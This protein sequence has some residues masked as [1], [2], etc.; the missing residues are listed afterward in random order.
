MGLGVIRHKIWHDLWENK[1]RTLRVVTIIAIG[2]F[3]IGT[4]LGGKEFII[5]DLA[6]TWQASQPATI[7]LAV[8]PGVD[9]A[10]LESLENLRGIETV[11]GWF[12][13]TIKWRRSPDEPWVPAILIALDDYGEQPIRQVKL[14]NGDWPSRK[15][16]G[17]QRGRE[18][19]INDHVYL[20][21]NDEERL[22]QFNGI[23]Y[24][25]AHP[26]PF[27]APEPMFFTAPE[28]FEQLTG[29]ARSSL[30]L[31]TIPNYS[32]DRVQ[33]AADLIQHELEKQGVEVS[34]AIPA[35]GG[36]KTRTSQPDRF[37]VQ[38][39]LDGVFLMLT[40]MAVAT[41]ILGLF[42]VYNTINAIIAQ[43]VNQ[44]GIMKAIGAKFGKILF[45][46]FTTVIVYAV[47][48]LLIAVPLGAF[49]AHGLRL[50]MIG[51]IRMIPG[52]LEISTTAVSVQAVIAL[53]S[54]LVIAIIPIL[55]GARITV[56]EAISIYGLGGASGLLDRLLLKLQFVPRIISLTVSNTFRNKNRVVLTQITLVGA[57]VIFMMVMSTRTSLLYTFNDSIFTIFEVNVLLDL[58]DGERISEVE[59]VT[60]SHPEVKAVEVWGTAKGKARLKGQPESNDDNEVKLRGLP[61]PSTTYIPQIRAGRWLQPG[62]TYAV[63]LNQTLAA[64]MDVSVGNWITIDIPGKREADWQVVGLVFEPMD[65]E[66]ALMPRDTLL[67]ESRQVGRGKAIRVQTIRD[68]AHSEFNTAEALRTLYQAKGYEVVAST[69]NT[70]HQVTAQRTEQMSILIALLSAMAVMIAVVGAVALSGTLSINVMERIREIGVMR[71]IGASAGVVAGQFVGEGLILGW[72]SWLIAIPLS[73]PVS[74]KVITT[75]SGLLNIEL[76]YQFSEIGIVYWFVIITVLATIASWFPAQKAAQ[77]S[78]RESLAYS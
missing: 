78:V 18:L 20:E 57:G 64:E 59:S 31:A 10:M 52:P 15:L 2:A 26:P 56:R 14:D 65:Q 47:L 16:M 5:K 67:I 50:A 40:V 62:D 34:P 49:G 4:T 51:R 58:K 77:T 41:L 45:I 43:Q 68:D 33:A 69:M 42:L 61:I 70:T 38:D 66:S 1:G 36:F 39:A 54:P 48:A 53:L 46:Y 30:V 55:A 76:I 29:E 32:D 7:G 24:N 74:Q 63:V 3:A 6:R 21:I 17:V 28:R 72:L 12:Q 75:L 25:A 19:D 71:A 35:P 22:V 23:L 27:V 44:I 37:I 9:K 11:E 73:I 8:E 60:L 13:A